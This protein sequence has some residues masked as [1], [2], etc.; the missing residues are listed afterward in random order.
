V[1]RLDD[2][3]AERE[4]LRTHRGALHAAVQQSREQLEQLPRWA[5]RRRRTLSNTLTSGQQQ[6]RQTDPTLATL[7][8]EID[9]LTRQVAH[10]TRQRQAS[11]VT[12]QY[13]PP[14][15]GWDLTRAL[16]RARRGPGPG[17]SHD[18]PVVTL[19]GRGAPSRGPERDSRDGRSR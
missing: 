3:R 9:R 8:A 6:L 4:Q 2:C 5:P 1:Q 16:T 14:S 19:P 15:D 7:D 10:H 17:D 11:D 13:R 18:L 12:A